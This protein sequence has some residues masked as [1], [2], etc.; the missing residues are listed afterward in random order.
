MLINGHQMEKRDLK[1]KRLFQQKP[2]VQKPVPKP[3]VPA[4]QNSPKPSFLELKD[5]II[6]YIRVSGP[7]I[8]IQISKAFGGDTMFAGAVLSELISNRVLKIT[9][10]KIGGSPVYYMP[11]QEEK[12]E[13]LRQHLGQKPKQAYD[14]LKEKQLV[15][16]SECEPWQRVALRELKDFA[17][18]IPV[19]LDDGSEEVFWRWHLLYEDE[20]KQRITAIASGVPVKL[21][22]AA[23]KAE[24]I[25]PELIEPEPEPIAPKKP[26]I[27]DPR[28]THDETQEEDQKILQPAEEKPKARL[29]EP[30]EGK[31]RTPVSKKPKK[32]KVDAYKNELLSFLQQKGL[33][34]MEE[35]EMKKNEY[36]FVVR[37]ESNVGKL[38][39]MAIAKK[40]KKLSDDDIT[41]AYSVG[42]QHKLPVILVGK[43]LSAKAEKLLSAGMKGVAFIKL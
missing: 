3:S 27:E 43:E 30:C 31:L 21:E 38:S 8:P 17:F 35:I 33:E 4:Q 36:G 34:V 41:V 26:D 1:Q 42:V 22:P 6:S 20:A 14:L 5:K 29:S 10:A 2:A 39:Y 15:R 23:P 28:K 37:V 9:S 13:I 7:V 24:P 40:K 16:D 32:E 19:R 12:L 18:P 11:G 25:K